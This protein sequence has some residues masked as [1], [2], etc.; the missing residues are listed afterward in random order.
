MHY[1]HQANQVQSHYLGIM[2]FVEI[3]VVKGSPPIGTQHIISQLV[4]FY[5]SFLFLFESSLTKSLFF[6]NNPS[7]SSLYLIVDNESMQICSFI[8]KILVYYS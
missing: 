7:S 8:S 2:Y 4:L 3:Y 5:S 6:K 1:Q